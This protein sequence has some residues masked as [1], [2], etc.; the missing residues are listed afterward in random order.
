M[1]ATLD[2]IHRD[3]AILDRAIA[4]REPL[5][6]V[7]AGV[8]AATMVPRAKP[9]EPDFLARAQRIWGEAPRGKPLSEMVA[10]GRD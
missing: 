1:T 4:R 3:P 8:V 2:E 5:D 9:A 7:T 10:E 6:I